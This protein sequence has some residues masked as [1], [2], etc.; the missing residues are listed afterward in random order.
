MNAVQQAER[1]LAAAQRRP[2]PL[3]W[4]FWLLLPWLA[5]SVAVEEMWRWW[6]RRLR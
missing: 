5:W 1:V 3:D 6:E 4:G 2:D